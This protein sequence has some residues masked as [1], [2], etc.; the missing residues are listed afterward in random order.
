MLLV[1][2]YTKIVKLTRFKPDRENIESARRYRDKLKIDLTS[3]EK[4]AGNIRVLINAVE[5]EI[6]H[7]E[8]KDKQSKELHKVMDKIPLDDKKLACEHHKK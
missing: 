4:R 2:P 5:K 7:W 1:S 8:F 6:A 3:S